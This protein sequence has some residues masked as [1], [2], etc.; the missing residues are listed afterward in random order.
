M[1]DSLVGIGRG[2]QQIAST[3]SGQRLGQML[4][5][6]VNHSATYE[7]P[8]S[9]GRPEKGSPSQDLTTADSYPEASSAD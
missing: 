1:W 4:M 9:D 5:N 6:S 3:E 8:L 2:R 7:K